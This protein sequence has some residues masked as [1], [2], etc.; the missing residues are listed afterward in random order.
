VFRG[1]VV[2]NHCSNETKELIKERNNVQKLIRLSPNEKH[3]IQER[4]K[5][6]RNRVTN[7]IKKDNRQFNEERIDKAGDEK[8]IWK[9]QQES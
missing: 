2:G 3:I 1:T 5:K 7:Q 8:E 9:L 4:Y 6:V